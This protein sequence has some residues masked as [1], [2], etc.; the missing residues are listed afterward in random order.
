MHTHYTKP[1]GTRAMLP[2]YRRLLLRRAA[3]ALFFTVV[4]P[5]AALLGAALGTFITTH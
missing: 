1:D 3:F 2:S 5:L 4:L